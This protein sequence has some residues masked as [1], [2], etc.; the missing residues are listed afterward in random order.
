VWDFRHTSDFLADYY[1]TIETIQKLEGIKEELESNLQKCNKFL[2][3]IKNMKI[4]KDF[5]EETTGIA[6][7][8]DEEEQELQTKMEEFYP[9]IRNDALTHLKITRYTDFA[10][11]DWSILNEIDDFL[12]WCDCYSSNLSTASF[13]ECEKLRID[14]IRVVIREGINIISRRVSELQEK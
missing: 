3:R 13:Y 6:I 8:T 5:K 11:E 14:E 4:P 12:G 2:E 9:I 1:R 7:L 10:K